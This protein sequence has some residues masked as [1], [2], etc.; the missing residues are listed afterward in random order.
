MT[1]QKRYNPLGNCHYG[2]DPDGAKG[3]P[4]FSVICDFKTK[5]SLGI[6]VVRTQA[7]PLHNIMFLVFKSMVMSPGYVP[8]YGW[9]SKG[10]S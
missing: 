5:S 2:I 1:N 7:L 6:T 3:V 9:G 8:I 4:I 10:N